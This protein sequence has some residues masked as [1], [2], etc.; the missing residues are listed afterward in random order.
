MT[1]REAWAELQAGNT[2]FVDGT[3]EHPSQNAARRAELSSS[4]HP[5]AIVFGCSDSRVAAEIVF[6]RGLGDLFVVRTA[7]HVV[8]TSVI[9]SIEFG[10]EMLRTPLIVVLGHDSCGAVAAAAHTLETGEQAPGFVRSV[11]DKVIPSVVSITAAGQAVRDEKDG[12]VDPVALGNVHVRHTLSTLH[13]YSAA[14]ANAVAE[15]R[16]ALVGLEYTLTDGQVRLVDVIGDIGEDPSG[17]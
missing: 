7:G 6:D 15:G 17:R 3:V 5:F 16:L 9:G 2:R 8:D 12:R 13:G 11:V 1:P 14:I 4:Q 10:V